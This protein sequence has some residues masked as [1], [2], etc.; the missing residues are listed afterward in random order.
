MQEV[1]IKKGCRFRMVGA[2]SSELKSLPDPARVAFL[3]ARIPYIKPRLKV[4][5]G[6]RVLIGSPLFEDKYLP[7]IQFLS[8][9]GGVVSDIRLG[10]RRVVQAIVID[11]QA[12]NEPQCNFTKLPLHILEAMPRRR[13]V[14]HILEG[15]LWWIFRE[16]PFRNIPDPRTPP[17]AIILNLAAKE[18]FQPRPQV[19]LHNRN[20]LMAYGLMVLR[21]LA[22]GNLMVMTDGD[23]ADAEGYGQWLTHRVKGNYPADD[24]GVLLY[25][26]KE[27]TRLNR[28][29]F[30]AGQDLI[31]LSQLLSRGKYPVERIFTVAGSHAPTRCHFRARLGIPLADLVAPD[32]I[33]PETRMIVGGMLRGYIGERQDFMG[34]YES[35]LNLIPKGEQAEFLSLFKPGHDK[36]SFSRTFLSA[37]NPGKMVYDCNLRGNERACIACLH[38]TDVCP[39]DIMPHMAYK[40]VLAEEVEESLEHGLLDCVECGLCSFVC[41]SKI[42]LSQTFITAKALYADESHP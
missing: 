30:V 22:R 11:R 21:K 34:H 2:P 41:P 31:L 9:A 39:V 3:P 42:E 18:P 23:C 36:P 20:E 8:P 13:L 37:L 33:G 17:P 4:A 38:C 25:H 1:N 26:V 24:P 35:A 15:G 14:D 5:R 32:T 7:E 6:D 19:Y 16:L 28:A 27:S 12:G 40:A 29:W 10:P